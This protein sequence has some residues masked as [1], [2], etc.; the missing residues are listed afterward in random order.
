MYIGVTNAISSR[1]L[2]H[3]L[4]AGN[5]KTFAGRYHCYFLVYYEEFKYV[6][7]A[8]LREKQLKRWS[9]KKKDDLIKTMNPDLRFLNQELGL[10]PFGDY[11]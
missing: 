9:R 2:E 11:A 6:N 8:I 4:N 10:Y 7:D 3:G 1:V 5:A